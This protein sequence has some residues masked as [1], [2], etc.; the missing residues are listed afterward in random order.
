[1]SKKQV[2]FAAL[3]L[4]VPSC[5]R[6]GP[7][8]GAFADAAATSDTWR[9]AAAEL[10]LGAPP[11]D[12]SHEV[13]ITDKPAPIA[14]A[15]ALSS[16]SSLAG[17]ERAPSP[18]SGPEGPFVAVDTP[19]VTGGLVTDI[20]PTVGRMRAGF[21]ACY[22][23]W[24]DE[25]EDPPEAS[26]ISLRVFVM[27]SGSVRTVAVE[28]NSG[29]SPSAVDCFVHRAEVATFPPPVGG[30]AEVVLPITLRTRRP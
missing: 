3:F 2:F 8:E 26:A 25:E 20:S 9:S 4:L 7:G 30:A 5:K 16:S 27:P 10:P 23:R 15:A 13:R 21:R 29:L 17:L 11:N 28:A 1:M 18:A 24:L 22:A 6:E 12:G 19:R 14:S